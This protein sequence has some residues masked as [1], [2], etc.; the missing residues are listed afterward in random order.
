MRKFSAQTE[1]EISKRDLFN[2]LQNL[3]IRIKDK[4]HTLSSGNEMVTY[5]QRDDKILEEKIANLENEIAQFKE[6]NNKL[7]TALDE[8]NNEISALKDE[9]IIFVNREEQNNETIKQI[10]S[11]LEKIENILDGET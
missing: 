11:S 2:D 10:E 7:K 5:S 8:A 9:K 6:E 3:E 1:F 4:L